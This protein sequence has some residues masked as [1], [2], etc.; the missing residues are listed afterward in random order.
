MIVCPESKVVFSKVKSPESPSISCWKSF[1]RAVDLLVCINIM[2]TSTGLILEGKTALDHRGQQKCMSYLALTGK[3]TKFSIISREL[4]TSAQWRLQLLWVSVNETDR[5]TDRRTDRQVNRQTGG[6]TDRRTGGQ[7][8]RQ[9]GGQTDRRTDRQ[10]DR[11]TDRWTD[12]QTGGRHR[13]VEGQTQ[14]DTSRSANTWPVT[15]NFFMFSLTKIFMKTI[16][17]CL[18]RSAYDWYNSSSGLRFS[19]AMGRETKPSGQSILPAPDG[20]ERGL[21][22]DHYWN[23]TSGFRLQTSRSPTISVYVG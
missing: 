15:C 1:V 17:S 5:W 23:W 14:T 9:T 22:P 11:Q 8:D 12:R 7:T 21:A 13:Q 18:F 19:P 6:R 10:A 4:S 3:L 2:F 20:R 16:R